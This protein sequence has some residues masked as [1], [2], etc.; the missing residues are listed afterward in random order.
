MKRTKIYYNNFDGEIEITGIE[1][2]ASSVDLKFA[3]GDRVAKRYMGG[4]PK[5]SLKPS[6]GHVA[7]TGKCDSTLYVSRGMVVDK[8]SFQKVVSTMKQAGR[9]LQAI[10]EEVAAA[11]EKTVLI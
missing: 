10:K 1:N 5:Y 7:V 6:E 3:F 2:A 9:R 8:V 11:E 4:T